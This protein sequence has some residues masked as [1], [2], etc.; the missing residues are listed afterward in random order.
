MRVRNSIGKFEH[1][2]KASILLILVGV[3]SGC[4]FPPPPGRLGRLAE[5]GSAR[6]EYRLGLETL[7]GKVT[8]GDIPAYDAPPTCDAAVYWWKKSAARGYAPAEVLLGDFFGNA[9][10]NPRV[11]MELE[12]D[13]RSSCF[14]PSDSDTK[15]RLYFERALPVYKQAATRGSARAEY[16]LGT[17][18]FDGAGVR[19]NLAKAIVWERKA[20]AQ[21]YANAAVTLGSIYKNANGSEDCSDLNARTS[22]TSRPC[23][24]ISA[25]AVSL[26][27]HSKARSQYYYDDAAKAAK[28]TPKES[29]WAEY[30]LGRRYCGGRGFGEGLSCFPSQL[31]QA[32]FWLQKAASYGYGPATALYTAMDQT[33][34]SL[35]GQ[36]AVQQAVQR[37]AREERRRARKA[38]AQGNARAG[39]SAKFKS[40]C[41]G[42]KVIKG[43]VGPGFYDGVCIVSNSV[44]VDDADDST[45]I[46]SVIISPIGVELEGNGLDMSGDTIYSNVCVRFYGN[47][48]TNN[49]IVNNSCTGR[50]T[51]RPS[52][53]G[54]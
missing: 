29:V 4:G 12:L 53:F 5:Q 26:M 45:I 46:N 20:A 25:G 49:S 47:I 48:L 44:G 10:V 39:L 23:T 54:Q 16:I 27:E 34:E 3:L 19:T 24:P 52:V 22:E 2:R 43:P 42:L 50:M 11:A 35:Y 38:A 51:N 41:Q 13:N 40:K 31:R 30:V 36:Q 32:L 6:A 37:Q 17:M 1:R 21:G 15:A 8:V 14:W 18:Y 7:A 33:Y 28:L 9:M